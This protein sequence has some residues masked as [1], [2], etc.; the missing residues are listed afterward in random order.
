MTRKL[1]CLSLA[2]IA[3]AGC[4]TTRTIIAPC[5]GKDQAIPAEPDKLAPRLTGRA[6]EDVRILAGGLIRWQNYGRGMRQIV[7][8]CRG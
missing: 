7:E 2:T 6:D 5:I 8:S 1:I 4:Q 3:L